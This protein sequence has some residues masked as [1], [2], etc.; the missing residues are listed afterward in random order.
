ML[1]YF[2]T[3]SGSSVVLTLSK[4]H[5]CE[6]QLP[7]EFIPPSNPNFNIAAFRVPDEYRID[8]S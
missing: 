7:L 8:N 5:G 1:R 6:A 4:L 3:R 2:P